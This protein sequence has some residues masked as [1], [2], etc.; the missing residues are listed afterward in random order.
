[1]L[2]KI[3]CL[4]ARRWHTLVFLCGS[5]GH[6]IPKFKFR[7]VICRSCNDDKGHIARVCKK[8]GVNTLTVEEELFEE[9][10]SCIR[11]SRIRTKCHVQRFITIRNCL[12]SFHLMLH[13]KA[14]AG[15][16]LSYQIGGHFRPV[17]FASCTLT[18]AQRSYS[19]LEKASR[20]RY[21]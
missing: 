4:Q 7:K 11:L 2:V 15:A 9:S 1:M 18:Q 5:G 16:I 14:L 19:Q 3:R 10:W 13:L 21:F 8:R 6:A 20:P 12:S 17:A